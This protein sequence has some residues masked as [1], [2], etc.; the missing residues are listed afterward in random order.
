MLDSLIATIAPHHCSDCGRLGSIYCENCKN[1][2]ISHS[3]DGCVSCGRLSMNGICDKCRTYYDKAWCVGWRKD[4]LKRLIDQYKFTFA[5]AAA[6]PLADMLDSVLPDLPPNSMVVPVPTV[7][8]HIRQRGFDH[9]LL[10]AKKLAKRRKLPVKTLITR[11]TK[12]VQHK[13]ANAKARLEQAKKAFSV[14]GKVNPDT[15]YVLIDD[16]V[17]TGATINYAAKA[18]KDAGANYV[19]VAVVTRQPID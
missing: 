15:I 9:S 19:F 10:I 4:G 12:D 14:A 8:Q 16:I 2:H 13:A 18:L 3:F 5:V 17:T 6:T 11:N 1:N 7:G